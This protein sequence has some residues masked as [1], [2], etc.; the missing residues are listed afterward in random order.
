MRGGLQTPDYIFAFGLIAM[1][2]AIVTPHP[3]IPFIRALAFTSLIWA[4]VCSLLIVV[5][6]A[7][8]TNK[9]F[10]VLLVFGAFLRLAVHFSVSQLFITASD[11]LSVTQIDQHLLV[12]LL[13]FL[14]VIVLIYLLLYLLL[15]MDSKHL[16]FTIGKVRW[17]IAVSFSRFELLVH[18]V[19]I[20]FNFLTSVCLFSLQ[21][22]SS[23]TSFL[24]RWGQMTCLILF[25][26]LLVGMA[27]NIKAPHSKG[28]PTT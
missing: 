14:L 3:P 20:G 22:G 19:L 9:L 4:V 27:L 6:H 25:P 13:S 11:Y 26:A 15:E 8:S 18:L 7:V 24:L 28:N 10:P 2:A 12:T 5:N 23:L 17:S 1:T 16:C 21:Q